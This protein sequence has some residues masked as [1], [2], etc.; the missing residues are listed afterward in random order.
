MVAENTYSPGNI[1]E[2]GTNFDTIFAADCRTVIG[3]VDH[4]K[5]GESNNTDV[6]TQEVAGF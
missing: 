3:Y 5:V 4:V 1:G 2:K 6:S